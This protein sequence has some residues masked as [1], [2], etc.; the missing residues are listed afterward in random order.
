[1]AQ[2]SGC[3]VV[4]ALVFASVP[5]LGQAPRDPS[6][7]RFG[8]SA[9]LIEDVNP[10]DA[11][12]AMTVWVRAVG[13]AAGVYQDAHATAFP[14]LA[15]LVR[16]ADDTDLFALPVTD[17]LSVE[18]TIAGEPCMTYMAS[19]EVEV[20]YL[21]VAKAGV[22]ALPSLKGQRLLVASASGQ[23]TI[24]DVWLDVLLMESGLPPRERFWPG[25][26][27]VKKGSQALLSVFFDQGDVALVT[28]A[29][30]DT[31]VEL[32]PQLARKL[33]VVARSQRLLHGVICA[34]K[35]MPPELRR[36][37]VEKATTIHENPQF[38]QTF[39]VLRMNRLVPWDPHYLDAARSVT[40]KYRALLQKPGAR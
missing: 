30:F 8:F 37:Y 1:M 18:R 28:K 32:N 26:K 4:L 39:M 7:L 35:S 34:R 9:G 22:T 29:S 20:E 10:T 11:V 31:A 25:A 33:T 36:R 12:A 15:S 21:L 14:D 40:E 38:K 2:L 16:A 23:R 3:L 24:A 13:I 19:G 17:Y 5:I 27:L 6:V